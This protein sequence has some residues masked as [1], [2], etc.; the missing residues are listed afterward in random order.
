MAT[1]GGVRPQGFP[2]LL[3]VLGKR[4]RLALAVCVIALLSAGLGVVVAS[5]GEHHPAGPPGA[6]PS[7]RTP[8]AGGSV[9]LA[10]WKLS[11]PEENDDGDATSIEPATTKAPWLSR[12]P[13]GGLMFWAPTSGATTKNSEHP[14]T[15]LQSLTYFKAGSGPHTLTASLTLLQ[16]PQDGRGIILGQIHGADDISSVPYVMLRIQKN[17]LRVVVKQVQ[18]GDDLINYPLLN[19]VGLNSPISYTIADLG[20]GTMSFSATNNGITSQATAP[21]P[22]E[23][24]DATVRF[25]AGDYQQAN[26]SAGPQDGGRVIFHRIVQQ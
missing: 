5:T 3:S 10:G 20:N 24:H 21:I 14:R 2:Q 13:D 1:V 18:D 11:I 12:A 4:R 9:D 15:E 6:S 8:E 19:N 25:Q 23:F 17:Q 7:P 22:A 26:A 16:L